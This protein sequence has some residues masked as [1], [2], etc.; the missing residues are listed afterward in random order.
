M[1]MKLKGFIFTAVAA[2]VAF[3]ACQKTEDL[4][5][6][7]IKLSV[8]QLAFEQNA[9]SKEIEIL[10]TRDWSVEIP[11]DADWGLVYV[12]LDSNFNVVSMYSVQ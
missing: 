7:D 3:A 11:A 2:V 10:A 5:S 4:G 6:P 1:I 12:G 9:D 8:S